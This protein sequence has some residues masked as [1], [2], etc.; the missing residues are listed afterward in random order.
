MKKVTLSDAR[1]V[2]SFIHKHVEEDAKPPTGNQNCQLCTWCAEANFRGIHALPR[3]VYS[4][5]D[6]ILEIKGETIVEHP[7]REQIENQ[8]ASIQKVLNA[9]DGARFYIHVNWQGSQGGHEFIL[10]NINSDVYLFDAQAGIVEKAKTSSKYFDDVNYANSYVV[11]MDN[12]NLN[13]TLLKDA[14]DPRKTLPWDESKDIP[15]MRDHGMLGEDEDIRFIRVLVPSEEALHYM[16]SDPD[17]KRY[18]EKLHKDTYGE[19]L[20]DPET[21]EPIGHGFVYNGNDKSNEGFIFNIEVSPKYRK[22]GFG[23]IILDDCVKKFGGRDLTVDCDNA[24]AIHMYLK[25]GFEIIDK[26]NYSDHG[27]GYYMRLKQGGK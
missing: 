7:V 16:K 18:W 2:A 6:P 11:R 5:R 25:Y 26:G 3:P 27:E 22:Q 9:G 12:K 17:L 21:K 1:R 8:S 19:F 20:I 24:P 15:Y 14:T 10:M 4:P 13:T 23:T